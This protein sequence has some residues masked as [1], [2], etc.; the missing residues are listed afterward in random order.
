[1]PAGAFLAGMMSNMIGAPRPLVSYMGLIVIGW[2]SRWL[3]GRRWFAPSALARMVDLGV[4][5]LL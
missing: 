1:M 2:R 3:G 4:L 5:L